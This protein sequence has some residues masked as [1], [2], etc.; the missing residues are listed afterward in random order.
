MLKLAQ[1]IVEQKEGEFE[2]ESFKDQ[3]EDALIE[4]V[5]KKQA[6][7][8]LKGGDRLSA[9]RNVVNLMDALRRSVAHDS[10]M[11]AKAHADTRSRSIK[12]AIRRTLSPS[13]V[14]ACDTIRAICA[15]HRSR[16]SLRSAMKS[17]R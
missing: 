4:I 3:Y 10:G 6:H 2:P 11:P 15:P 5:K 9:P 8:P 14:K 7:L 12:K 17:C 1:H 16:A 13:S